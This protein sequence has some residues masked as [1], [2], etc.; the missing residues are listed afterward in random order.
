MIVVGS[1]HNGL[2]AAAY[3][4]KAGLKVLV[5][6]RA[7]YPG[8]GVASLPMAEPGFL[9]ERHSAIHQ[10]IQ[11]N[12]MI[13]RDELGLQSK[14]GLRYNFLEP[15]YAIIMEDM[16]IPIYQ[17]RERTVEAIRKFSPEDADAYDRFVAK[18]AA[19][20][21]I[22]L[23]SMFVPP[24]DISAQI[25]ASPYAEDLMRG[26]ASSS[27]DII[28]RE[29]KHEALQ[30]ALLRFVTEIQLAH[31]R[32]EGTGLMVYLAFG[33]ADKYGLAAPEGAGNGFTNSVIRCL[34]A[35]GGEVRLNTEVVKVLNEGGRAVGV[36]TR[37]G[38]IRAKLGVIGQI[39]PHQLDQLVDGLDESV[40]AP[41]KAAKLS[42]FSL[43]VIHAALD[44]PLQFKAGP[45]ADRAVMNT[46]CPGNLDIMLESYDQMEKGL[47]PDNIMI[48]ASSISTADPTRC[49][50]GK[51]LLHCVV[52]CK[53][54]NAYGG[55]DAWDRIKD[56]WA[57][58]VFTYFSRYL[59]NFTPDIVRAY[60]VVT[61][62][63]HQGDSPSFQRGDICGLAMSAG[64]MGMQRP[65]PALAQYR[66]PGVKGLYL[67]GPFMHPGGGVWGGGRPVAMRV[68][69][70]LGI[71]FDKIFGAK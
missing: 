29:F 5:L 45:V 55:W 41:A 40:T 62:R 37:A 17:E 49:P 36:R 30:V 6:E 63:D 47:L 9:S 1:G 53:A 48:G 22:L 3:L 25:A 56:E 60:E 50:P 27:L 51:A 43:F 19:I 44:R 4:A 35:H 70:D 2:T 20:T 12:P 65:T 64:Q 28:T 67:A 8:G 21:D 71:D 57:Q 16:V 33:L 18:C 15:A 54:D 24:S 31:P 23:P 11:A 7:S 68:L 14:Y 39:H 46:C 10:L 61:P 32:T 34:E 58:K 59:K 52:M 38:E 69:E 66:V 42:E 13:T 26:T